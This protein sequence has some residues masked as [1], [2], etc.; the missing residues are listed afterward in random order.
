MGEADD[1]TRAETIR[2]YVARV[3][4]KISQDSS[5]NVQFEKIEAWSTWALNEADRIDP[6]LSGRFLDPVTDPQEGKC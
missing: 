1:L 2:T 5:Q 3:K 4:E 6:I